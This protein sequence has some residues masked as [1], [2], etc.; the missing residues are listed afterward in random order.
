ME[1]EGYVF[2]DD[3][4]YEKNHFWARVEGDLVVTGA[5]EFVSKQ[6]G[7]ITFVDLPQEDDDLSQGKP[8]GSIE[9]G[10]WVG[11]IY[12]VVSGQ[13]AEVNQD[14]EDEPEK[15]NADPYGD[16][17]IC[18]IRPSNL[19]GDI[20]NLMSPDDSFKQFVLDEIKKIEEQKK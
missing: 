3:L 1:F 11:R 19:A 12:A 7:E 9:S 5:T 4:K 8:F 18:K 15:I 16:G 14:L 6:A 17:W 13:V 10:K 20:A 2:P